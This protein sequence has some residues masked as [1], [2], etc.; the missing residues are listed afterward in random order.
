MNS[1]SLSASAVKSVIK[2]K[3]Q[4]IGRV[5]SRRL[6]ALVRVPVF[7]IS[8]LLGVECADWVLAVSGDITWQTK[9]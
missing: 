7:N 8:T 2:S 9:L 3:F 5:V 6:G 4:I 1:D